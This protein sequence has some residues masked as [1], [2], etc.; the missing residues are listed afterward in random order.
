MTD[1]AIVLTTINAKHKTSIPLYDDL[2]G[3]LGWQLVVVGDQKTP[4]MDVT[5]GVYLSAKQQR[6]LP[7][8]LIKNLPWNCYERKNI[9]YIYAKKILGSRIIISTDDDN[10]PL[11]NYSDIERYLGNITCGH[12]VTP[13]RGRFANPLRFFSDNKEIWPRGLPLGSIDSYAVEE[14][15]TS[16]FV[17]VVAALWN[18]SPDFDAIG[19]EYFDGTRWEFDKDKALLKGRDTLAPYNTQNTAFTHLSI[20]RQFLCPGIARTTDIWASYLSQ[21]SGQGGE[22]M[23]ISPTVEQHRNHHTL[24]KD[25]LDEKLVFLKTETLVETAKH[26]SG[27]YYSTCESV[28]T[29]MPQHF[30][31]LLDDW[32]EDIT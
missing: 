25:L 9:G 24:S 23:F 15:Q 4:D 31:T 1:T 17:D 3:E 20:S 30:M 26:G 7:F 27:C 16:V 14:K 21:L 12:T 28:K 8:R 13:S 19:H 32:M 2:C 18:G 6:G 5:N 11:D 22:V 10:Y 29:L